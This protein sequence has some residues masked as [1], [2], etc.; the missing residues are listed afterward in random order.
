[1]SLGVPDT[2]FKSAGLIK[3]GTC[4][5]D[6]SLG[7][8]PNAVSLIRECPPPTHYFQSFGQKI[9]AGIFIS[10]ENTTALA[11]VSSLG[12]R[13]FENSMA[14][15]TFNTSV[16]RWNSNDN[17]A[18]YPSVVFQPFKKLSP[19]SIANTFT[20]VSDKTSSANRFVDDSKLFCR[21]SKFGF[22]Y[23]QDQYP[24]YLMRLL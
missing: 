15:T 3:G 20:N 7:N 6:K 14:R 19:C 11:S 4:V 21:T 12:Q 2:C 1:M 10:V 24:D 17:F 9:T 5:L 23:K 16:L 22:E 8:P 18:K 13:L